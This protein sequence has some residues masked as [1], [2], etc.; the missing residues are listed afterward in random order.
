M[1]PAEITSVQEKTKV[2]IVDGIRNYVT[3]TRHVIVN[4]REEL[5]FET[6]CRTALTPTRIE[7]LQRALAARDL[8][9]GPITGTLTK[10]TRRAIRSYQ[11]PRGLESDIL[12]LGT[13]E[14]LGVIPIEV[15]QTPENEAEKL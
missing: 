1:A 9:R 15:K 3:E 8:Y 2:E 6:P 13:A 11:A 12:S 10:R 5:W 7:T 14:A 4:E